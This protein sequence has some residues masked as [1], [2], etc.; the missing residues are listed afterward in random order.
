MNT[1][2]DQFALD[3]DGSSAVA[4]PMP[5]EPMEFAGGDEGEAVQVQ[6]AAQD[7][8]ADRLADA[9]AEFEVRPA[10][11][12]QLMKLIGWADPGAQY[13][14]ASELGESMLAFIGQRVVEEYRLDDQS[15]ST[16]LEATA[17]AEAMAL[18]RPKAKT[19]PWPGASNVVFPLITQAA[20]QFAARA[21]PAIVQNRS[22]V[23]AAIVGDDTGEP[24]TDPDGQPVIG[25]DHQPVWQEGKEPSAKA[26]RGR[27]ISEHMSY[28]LLEEMPEWEDDTDMLLSV[29]PIVGADFRKTYFD[30]KLGRNVSVR[31]PAKRF[32]VNYWARSLSTAPRITEEFELYPYEVRERVASK[33][34]LSGAYSDFS[35]AMN[36]S[37]APMKFI[38]Q[39]CRIDLDSDGYP[40]PYIV[41][42]HVDSS[43]VAR[44]TANFEAEKIETDALTGKVKSIP[45]VQ[46]YSQYTFLPNVEGGIYGHGW[47]HYLLGLNESI[48]T[49]LN[50]LFDAGHQQNAGGGFI[51]KGLSLH[52]GD[53]R[54]KPGEYK[55]VNV[56]GTTVRENVVPLDHKGPNAAIITLLTML[57]ESG[58]D[59]SAIKDIL[60]GELKAQTMSPTVFTA[61]VEQGL[62]V[63]T[64][65]YKRIFRALKAELE[66]LYRLNRIHLPDKKTFKVADKSV[67]ISRADYEQDNGVEPVADPGMVVDAQKLARAEVLGQ[68]KDDPMMNGREIRL[69]M[70]RAANI[71]DPEKYLA[72]D[73][74]PNPEML[75]K[76]GQLEINR[77]VAKSEVIKNIAAATKLMAEA[78]EKV[79]APF[80]EWM[81]TQIERL[82]NAVEGTGST[83]G[84]AEA[85]PG[86]NGS[87]PS[88]SGD[89]GDSP[90]PA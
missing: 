58:K 81:R 57:I 83:T 21:Y 18:Q 72:G 33:R 25:P 44:I 45:A 50:M 69:A 39:H 46:Y 87:A 13:N 37:Q 70:L 78:D 61:V 34:Y 65:I 42:V 56:P 22:V 75:V 47:A 16:W 11:D 3:D 30:A 6:G 89:G 10:D 71:E 64:A 9:P 53:V 36:D 76:A 43:T 38:E 48:N 60:T 2:L 77:M 7:A 28:Q 31:V 20:T 29:L 54:F 19:T 4:P 17:K 49:T 41:I 5:V 24:K 1:S 40:E 66:K 8:P 32:V 27:R 90:V 12:A 14:I 59:I 88:P 35:T 55:M 68:F 73:P 86:A 85:Q 84:S 26:T 23:K 52:T 63:F 67:T 62:K 80:T 51:G 82:Q 15:R 79:T 74:A